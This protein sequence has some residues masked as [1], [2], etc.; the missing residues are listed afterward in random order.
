MEPVACPLE[1]SGKAV[2]S[3]A[4]QA[5]QRFLL[6]RIELAAQASQQTRI[7]QEEIKALQRVRL[8]RQHEIRKPVEPRV[9]VSLICPCHLGSARTATKR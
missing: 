2:D 3:S 5:R 1:P 7:V 4:H 6:T 9:P 8:G